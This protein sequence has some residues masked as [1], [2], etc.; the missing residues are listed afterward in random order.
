[1]YCQKVSRMVGCTQNMNG[2]HYC[3]IA[4]TRGNLL[5]FNRKSSWLITKHQGIITFPDIIF[6]LLYIIK[7]MKIA[8]KHSSF[9]PFN[10][11][12]IPT[13]EA[14]FC[15]H[16]TC[17]VLCINNFRFP[18]EYWYCLFINEF[19]NQLMVMSTNSENQ[20]TNF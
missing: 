19:W 12:C 9:V 3:M 7:L 5:T 16:D 20:C 13:K 6:L 17:V 18:F 4:I 1:M 11:W 2:F 15:L 10:N 14:R 8:K